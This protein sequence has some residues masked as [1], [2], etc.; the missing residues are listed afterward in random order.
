MNKLKEKGAKFSVI[1][2]SD[3]RS[4]QGFGVGVIIGAGCYV[5]NAF[6]SW[7]RS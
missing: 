6:R 7:G 3:R 5:S 2:E 4:K 1:T